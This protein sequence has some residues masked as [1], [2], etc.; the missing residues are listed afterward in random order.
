MQD[1]VRDGL[2]IA[3]DLAASINIPYRGNVML[4]LNRAFTS[5]HT[6]L[7]VACGL[8][9]NT[10]TVHTISVVL[11][12]LPDSKVLGSLINSMGW[13][14]GKRQK[15][16]PFR[17]SQRALFSWAR[18]I[19][20]HACNMGSLYCIMHSNYMAAPCFSFTDCMILIAMF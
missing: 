4:T 12:V 10:M 2:R 5:H 16:V 3:C 15:A 7:L 6:R 8:E 11:V 1:H 13:T 14:G 17:R 19:G 18:C 20:V 9:M